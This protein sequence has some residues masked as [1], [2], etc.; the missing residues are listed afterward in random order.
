[1]NQRV[2]STICN[3]LGFKGNSFATV[4]TDGRYDSG[5]TTDFFSSSYCRSGNT[6]DSIRY[7]SLTLA[8]SCN[9]NGCR[10]NRVGIKCFNPQNCN[11]GDVRLMNGTVEREGRLEICASGVWGSI[12]TTNFAKSAAYV[13]CKQLGH[14]DVNGAII[15]TV[16]KYGV[17]DGPIVYSNVECFGHESSLNSCTKTVYPSFYCSNRVVGL[18]C[19]DLCDEGDVRLVGTNSSNEGLV[20]VC[21]D[22]SWGLVAQHGWDDGDARIVCKQLGARDPAAGVAVYNSSYAK[23]KRAVRYSNVHCNGNEDMLT[24]CI[25]HT[26]EFNYGRTLLNMPVAAVNCGI[27][28]SPTTTTTTT[29]Y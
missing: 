3:Q 14:N 7:C 24:D 29:S 22:K 9:I 16:N 19:L 12:C 28:S 8:N 20:E 26:F 17:G 23:P 15:D 5:T 11:E 27:D 2:A 1:M 6:Y 21:L 10:Y 13:A 18:V 25:H 4:I